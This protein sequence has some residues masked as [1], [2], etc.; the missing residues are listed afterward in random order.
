MEE[1]RDNDQYGLMRVNQ[2]RNGLI[3]RTDMTNSERLVKEFGDIIRYN[4]TWKK[5]LVWNEKY[6]EVDDGERNINRCVQ[7]MVRG[8]YDDALNTSDYKE[9]LEIEKFASQSESV[10]RINACLELA[11]KRDEVKITS[12]DLDKNMWLFNVE[13]GTF[14]FAHDTFREHRKEDYITKIAHIDFNI[15]A[16][17][18]IWENFIREIMNYDSDLIQFLQTAAGYGITGSVKEQAM[19]ILFGSGANGKSTFLNTIA[20]M[21][22]DYATSTNTETFIK[23]NVE[24]ISNDIARLRGARFVTT[25]ETEQGRKLSEPLIKQITGNDKLTARFLFSEYF[26]FLPTFKIFMATNHKPHIKGTDNGIWRRIRL[27]PFTTTIQTDKQ[28]KDLE[29]KL[30]AEQ[31]GILN[32]L[33]AGTLRWIKEG[34]S[35]PQII[36]NATDEYRG[37]MDIIGNFLKECCVQEVSGH[38]R[39]RELFKT[40]QSWCNDN[41]EHACS[42]RFFGLRLKEMGYKQVRTAEARHWQGI[43]LHA[44]PP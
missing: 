5:W 42:E 38:I 1:V 28:D 25:T 43:M 3:Q 12:D 35:T 9:R 4:S 17:C 26:I 33:L 24:K 36:T 2:L 31:S 37:E 40:Y 41:N 20:N 22:G 16:A 27:I 19:F 39:I 11:A 10:R 6:W 7:K 30:I 21:L 44:T 8:I 13:N 34:L 23:Q 15:D 14:D 29:Q 32:W 18:P